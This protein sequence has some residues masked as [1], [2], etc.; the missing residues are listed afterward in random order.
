MTGIAVCGTILIQGIST[1]V[2]LAAVAVLGYL[3]GLS[4]R[5]AESELVRREL[6]QR[7]QNALENSRQLERIAEGAIKATREALRQSSRIR[8]SSMA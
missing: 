1:S 2:A 3:V 4:R 6:D 5:E 7:L 8:E